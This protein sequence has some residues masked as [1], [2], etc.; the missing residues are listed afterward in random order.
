MLIRAA[1][2]DDDPK[3]LNKIYKL[4]VEWA[5]T[6]AHELTISKYESTFEFPDNR[7]FDFDVII[8][9]VKMSG[10]TGVEFAHELRTVNKTVP[11]VF[12]SDYVEYSLEGYEVG[13]IRFLNKNDPLFSCKLIE[14]MRCVIPIIISNENT[15]Y[16]IKCGNSY[17]NVPCNEIL[18]L[19]IYDHLLNIHTFNNI[20]K[21]RKTIESAI[22]CLPKHF[23]RCSRYCIVNMKYVTSVSPSEII[24]INGEK[25]TVTKLYAESIV[26]AFLALH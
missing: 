20:H 1:I 17:K 10:L 18:Y 11:L 14:T 8:L 3:Y 6:D 24:L 16:L 26:E 25:L 21:E 15:A 22:G 7:F 23:L 13:A 9:D 5:E 2:L 19:D 12:V 4:L